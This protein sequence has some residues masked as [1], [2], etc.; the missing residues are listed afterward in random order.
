MKAPIP[1]LC[2]FIV[3]LVYSFIVIL[4]CIVIVSQ[5]SCV[6]NLLGVSFVQDHEKRLV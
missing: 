6:L 5:T 4:V 3:I 1:P 2:S